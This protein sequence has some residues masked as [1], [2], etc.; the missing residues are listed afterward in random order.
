MMK[1]TVG[2]IVGKGFTKAY[3]DQ[4]MHRTRSIGAEMLEAAT[5]RHDTGLGEG[6]LATVDLNGRGTWVV[7]EEAVTFYRERAVEMRD[8]GRYR[9]PFFVALARHALSKVLPPPSATPHGIA[10]QSGLPTDWWAKETLRAELEAALRVAAAPWG[11]VA[12]SLAPEMTG[13]Y[14][15][16]LFEHPQ[17]LDAERAQQEVGVIDWGFRDV[18]IGLYKGG[19][20]IGGKSTPGGMMAAIEVIRGL[21]ASAY[22][23]TLKPSEVDAALRTGTVVVNGADRPL[24]AGTY[25]ALTGSI[26]AVMAAAD[27]VWTDRRSQLR[28]VIL[29]GGGIAYTGYELYRRLPHQ[30]RLVGLD[31][32]ATVTQADEAA[33][34]AN[35][36][37]RLLARTRAFAEAVIGTDPQMLPARGFASF[38]L[39][40]EARRIQ[41]LMTAQA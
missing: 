25:K 14:Y 1:H 9:E 3:S 28:A 8:E 26:S 24:P 36:E 38:A 6:G 5:T 12:V 4:R 41:K 11:D 17:R 37:A 32:A 35:D 30:A 34:G 31:L 29:G 15:G 7:G 16:W 27:D 19:K 40:S 39:F 13:V 18:N 23:V 21:I 20:Y 22:G 2:L 10:I 33:T